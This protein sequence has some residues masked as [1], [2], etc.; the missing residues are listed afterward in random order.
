MAFR[1]IQRCISTDPYFEQL[2]PSE[3]QR[4]LVYEVRS[5]WPDDP[6]EDYTCSC[7]AFKYTGRCKHQGIAW[8]DRCLW[9]E[10]EDGV[11][12]QNVDQRINFLCPRCGSPT[13]KDVID[14]E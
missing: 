14:Y 12:K 5:V 2:I 7:P 1:Q 4:N 10:E 6:A 8:A 11:E 13:I 3:S 9:S